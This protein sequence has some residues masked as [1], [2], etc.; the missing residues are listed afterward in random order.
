MV[1]EWTNRVCM[2]ICNLYREHVLDMSLSIHFAEG[3]LGVVLTIPWNPYGR[4]AVDRD[5]MG[6]KLE[7]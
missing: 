1:G 7:A 4:I 5:S 6:G 3:C 2:K